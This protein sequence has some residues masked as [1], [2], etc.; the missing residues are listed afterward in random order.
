ME[1][2]SGL[3][4]PKAILRGHKAQVHAATFI[5]NN[6][7]L[8]TADAEGYLVVWDLTIMRPR[9]V[10]RAHQKTVLGIREWG[11]QKLV[12]HGRDH[13]L[14]V[15][16]FRAEDEPSLSQALPLDD[17]PDDRPKPW[18]Q[19]VLPV[20][21][22]NFCA[23]AM[24]SCN[25]SQSISEST[26]VLIAAANPTILEGVDIYHLPTQHRIHTLKP[27]S[28]A[29]MPMALSLFHLYGSLHLITA[30]ENGAAVVLRANLDAGEWTPL[31]QS[32]AHSQPILSFDVSPCCTYFITSS[33]DAVVAKH[34]IPRDRTPTD[35]SNKAENA[36][37]KSQAPASSPLK[38]VNT[39]HSGQQSLKIRSDGTIFATAG[40]DS[41]VRVYSTKSLKEVAVLKWHQSGCYAVAFASVDA[42]KVADFAPRL[43]SGSST[44]GGKAV[45]D[46][47]TPQVTPI[48]QSKSPTFFNVKERRINH[49]KTA[50]WIAAGSKDGKVSLWDIY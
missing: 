14:I 5:W 34:P 25:G 44:E 20:N 24:A 4:Q 45:E 23:F 46:Q 22:M 49:A 17:I 37:E 50:H 9:A 12:T 29:G 26:E 42:A 41:K 13:E 10:W 19:H 6:E 38:A 33:A 30:Y 36:P 40:W 11:P 15:W 32:Q 27:S 39:K 3:P 28:G 1:P 31:Y 47:Q 8:V 21:S 18:M 48:P 43:T 7:R 16:K 35:D 2:S